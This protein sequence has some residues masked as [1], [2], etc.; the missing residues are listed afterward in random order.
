[1]TQRS[2]KKGMKS[3]NTYPDHYNYFIN[4]IDLL[5]LVIVTILISLIIRITLIVTI[6]L[7][8][9]DYCTKLFYFYIFYIPNI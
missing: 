2:Q 4:F 9:T 7:I 6:F 1:M 8:A 3:K 5:L